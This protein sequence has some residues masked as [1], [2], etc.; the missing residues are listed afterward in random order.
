MYCYIYTYVYIY[1][2]IT[3]IYIYI[4]VLPL[5]CLLLTDLQ[6]N[7]LF[8]MKASTLQAAPAAAVA[9][10]HEAFL[11]SHSLQPSTAR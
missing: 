5:G 4:H 9:G 8:V 10:Q 11:Q 7:L 3:Y 1:I 2:Y 6:Y